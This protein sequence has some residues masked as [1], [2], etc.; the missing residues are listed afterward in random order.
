MLLAIDN[1]SVLQPN[2]HATILLGRLILSK[3]CAMRSDALYFIILLCLTP[4]D[5]TRQG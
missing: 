2:A 1:M 5:F 4:A 3:D